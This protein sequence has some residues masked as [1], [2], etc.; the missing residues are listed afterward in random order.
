MDKAP[1]AKLANDS[2]KI[3]AFVSNRVAD[4]MLK[5]GRGGSKSAVEPVEV[6]AHGW[7]SQHSLVGSKT[8]HPQRH[9]RGETRYEHQIFMLH[10]NS[11]TSDWSITNDSLLSG[12]TKH[13]IN[14]VSGACVWFRVIK[15]IYWKNRN[16]SRMQ[17]GTWCPPNRRWQTCQW[18]P[19]SWP[20]QSSRRRRQVLDK[21]VYIPISTARHIFSWVLCAFRPGTRM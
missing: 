17:I 21:Y 20:S 19:A 7:W 2:T 4:S 13:V 12:C 1:E 6:H 9:P 16:V 15:F 11:R 5:D 14:Y 18:R 10:L 8:V 3:S